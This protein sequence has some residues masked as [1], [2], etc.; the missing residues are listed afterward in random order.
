MDGHADLAAG[1]LSTHRI[2]ALTDGIYA[3]AMTL[4]VID[5]KFPEHA[6]FA[7][8]QDLAAALLDLCPKFVAWALS[9]FVLAFFLVGHHRAF[10]L[11]QRCDS[12]LVWLNIAQLA[13]VSL[14]PFSCDLLGEHGAWV[15]S[16]VVY[17]ANMF[18]LALFALLISR[19]IRT[20][21][22]LSKAVVPHWVYLGSRIRVV[23]LM[24][25]SVAAVGLASL[26]LVP[27]TGSITFAIMAVINPFSRWMERREKRRSAEAGKL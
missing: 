10:S 19:H 3:V 11:V 16:Q 26:D 2:E 20:H 7:T 9:F 24:V 12:R 5:I 25:L 23:G 13:F 27:G 8:S 4:L 6:S 15:L 21:P 18:M 14:M 22:A 17:S 1:S